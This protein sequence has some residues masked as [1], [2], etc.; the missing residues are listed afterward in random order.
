[1][2]FTWPF[3]CS[4]EGRDLAV[5]VNR[6]DDYLYI[7]LGN[8]ERCPSLPFRPSLPFQ[9]LPVLSCLPIAWLQTAITPIP[10]RNLVSG[11]RWPIER[12]VLM[13]PRPTFFLLA[14]LQT[15]ITP[16]CSKVPSR[17]LMSGL[18]LPIETTFTAEAPPL[19]LP[20]GWPFNSH[21]SSSKHATGLKLGGWSHRPTRQW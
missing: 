16:L 12:A 17:N 3:H 2:N 18:R 15:A 19:F 13:K 11:L 21:N 10:S 6:V 7:R 14:G 9:S 5:W 8:G 4:S 20:I 1:M